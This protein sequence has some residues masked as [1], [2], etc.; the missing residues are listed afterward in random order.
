MHCAL[1]LH[2]HFTAWKNCFLHMKGILT[3]GIELTRVS[4]GQCERT[5]SK[6]QWLWGQGPSQVR[7]LENGTKILRKSVV[8][9]NK[10]AS[11][12]VCWA[13]LA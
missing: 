7:G 10:G 3:L 12:T 13:P 5:E 11:G 8:W 6:S 9:T 2:L 4:P 1:M